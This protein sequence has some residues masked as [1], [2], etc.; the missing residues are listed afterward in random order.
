VISGATMAWMLWRAL[1]GLL[2]LGDL[3]LFYQ[4]F[5]QGQNLMRSLLGNVGEIHNNSLFVGNL[6]EFL[7]LEPQIIDPLNP[8]PIPSSLKRGIRF[9]E[10]T[11][12]YPESDRTALQ[13]FNLTI[14]AGQIVAIVGDNGAGKSTLLKLLCRF[15]DPTAG[16][17]ETR[18][19]RYS[20]LFGE[21]VPTANYSLVSVVSSLPSNCRREYCHRRY[22]RRT[23]YSRN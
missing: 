10:V 15:Y 6:F 19:N 9:Q 13:N 22:I 20:Q 5:N 18:W 4:A 2:S 1:Q 3:A 21:G 23:E 7:K 8:L 17:I 11:F 12:S 14:P 16:R